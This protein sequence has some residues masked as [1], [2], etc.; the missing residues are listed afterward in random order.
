MIQIFLDRMRKISTIML[1]IRSFSPFLL[2]SI[3][4]CRYEK[5]FTKVPQN[6]FQMQNKPR[7][8][9]NGNT[10]LFEHEQNG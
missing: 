10:F 1:M 8:S 3:E 7:T 2:G 9:R 5:N 4:L 6:T